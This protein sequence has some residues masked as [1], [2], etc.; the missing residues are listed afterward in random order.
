MSKPQR[1]EGDINISKHRDAWQKA[2]IDPEN[3]AGNN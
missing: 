2:N 1:S 3:Q